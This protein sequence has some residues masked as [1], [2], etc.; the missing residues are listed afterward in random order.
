MKK[1]AIVFF[2]LAVVSLACLT[3]APGIDPEIVITETASPGFIPD[4]VFEL[5]PKI[6]IGAT[7][8][9][10]TCARV[11]AVDAL[12]VRSGPGIDLPVIGY[13]RSGQIVDIGDR[14]EGPWWMISYGDLSGYA[15]SKYL[16]LSQCWDDD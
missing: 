10:R 11:T 4:E 15:R 3:T 7:T 9:P 6:V 12:H 13:L 16:V 5:E 1:V 14:Q 8:A 2:A